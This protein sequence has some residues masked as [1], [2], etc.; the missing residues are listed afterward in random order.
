MS[1]ARKLADLVPDGLD[2]YEEGTWTPKI[3]ANNSEITNPNAVHGRYLRTGNLVYLSFYFYKAS[4]SAT[5]GTPGWQVRNMPFSGN[6][7]NGGT[8]G[9]QALTAGYMYINSTSYDS[10]RWQANATDIFT[11]Y[12]SKMSTSWS[13]SHIEFHGYGSLVIND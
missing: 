7:Y 10:H 5:P 4:G 1:N 12:G 11:L 2:S 6:Y 9:Y 8:G 13:S 3:Y